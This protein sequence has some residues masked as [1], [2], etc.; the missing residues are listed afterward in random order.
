MRKGSVDEYNS[1]TEA[2]IPSW[3]K[4]FTKYFDSH[5]NQ[6]LITCGKWVLE[7]LNLYCEETGV[8]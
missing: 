4:N 8:G 2:L 7:P 1:Y 5:I 3:P 6:D